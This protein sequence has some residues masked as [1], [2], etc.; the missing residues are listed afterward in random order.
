MTLPATDR[1]AR[2]DYES[3]DWVTVNDLPE[4]TEGDD[5]SLPGTGLIITSLME[6][7]PRTAHVA[8]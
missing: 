6:V 4:T 8:S 3:G 5:T 2:P 7:A 1:R